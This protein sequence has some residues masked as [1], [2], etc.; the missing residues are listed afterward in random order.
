MTVAARSCQHGWQDRGCP[1]RSTWKT[2]TRAGE[3]E[4][5]CEAHAAAQLGS[6][7]AMDAWPQTTPDVL[8]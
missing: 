5:V 7:Q 4:F 6:G 1:S 3:L 2:I 8:T